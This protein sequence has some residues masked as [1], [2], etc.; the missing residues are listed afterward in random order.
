MAQMPPT[1]SILTIAALA[2]GLIVLPYLLPL[3]GPEAVPPA[4]LADPGGEFITLHDE[5]LYVDHV[6]GSGEPVILVHGFGGST[7]SWWQVI[8]ALAEAGYDVYAVDLLG[9]GLSEKGWDHDYSH[10]AQAE[11]LVALMDHWGLE[12]AT[13]V[14]HS[15][16]GNVVAHVALAYPERVDRLVLVSAAIYGSSENML[17]VPASL[18]DLPPARR[19]AQVILRGALNSMAGDLLAS[20]ANDESVIPPEILAGY[21]RA[22]RTPG[23]DTGLLAMTRD[24]D[25]NGLPAPVNE[26]R[27]PVLILWGQQDSWVSPEDGVRLEQEIPGAERLEFAGVGHLPMHETPDAFNAGLLEFLQQGQK[28]AG[29]YAPD[30]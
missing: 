15:M 9:F 10:P 22:L 3:G 2:F 12:T 4:R 16:G 26:L 23:W 17:P 14:G 5:T 29:F 13:L 18:L 21:E 11:R 30:L 28:Q 25:R 27:M 1:L 8:P 20:A 7:V 19:W 24:A 6:P